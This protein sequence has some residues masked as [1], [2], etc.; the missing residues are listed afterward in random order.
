VAMIIGSVLAAVYIKLNHCWDVTQ[1]DETVTVRTR[2]HTV[3]T[4][5]IMAF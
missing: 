5:M 4:C 1:Q 2:M 3:F